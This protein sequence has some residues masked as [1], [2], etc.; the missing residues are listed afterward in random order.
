MVHKVALHL[1][2]VSSGVHNRQNRQISP[3]CKKEFEP[4]KGLQPDAVV[5]RKCIPLL[6]SLVSN[7][8]QSVALK[9]KENEI[10]PDV[11][12]QIIKEEKQE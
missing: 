12:V 6:C 8:C 10:Q 9:I 5:R 4:L 7:A 11:R 3:D 1:K 2:L